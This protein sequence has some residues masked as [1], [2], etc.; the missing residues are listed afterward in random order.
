MDII[1]TAKVDFSVAEKRWVRLNSAGVKESSAQ[2]RVVS[3]EF[4]IEGDNQVPI[5]IVNEDD[6]RINRLSFIYADDLDGASKGILP[7]YKNKINVNMFFEKGYFDNKIDKL[8]YEIWDNESSKG[9]SGTLT[10]TGVDS[11]IFKDEQVELKIEFPFPVHGNLP[12][13]AMRDDID[14][15]AVLG[16][17]NI[18]GQDVTQDKIEMPFYHL[19]SDGFY[20]LSNL[21]LKKDEFPN[22]DIREYIPVQA[23]FRVLYVSEK[24]PGMDILQ[25]KLQIGESF[26][27]KFPLKKDKNKS[28]HVYMSDNMIII[29]SVNEKDLIYENGRKYMMINDKKY[30]VVLL[31]DFQGVFPYSFSVLVGS[32]TEVETVKKY[33]DKVAYTMY[34]LYNQIR[35]DENGDYYEVKDK[36]DDY[37]L[38][39]YEAI[40]KNIYKMG[41]QILPDDSPTFNKFSDKSSSKQEIGIFYYDGHGEVKS[42]DKEIPGYLQDKE[43]F[44]NGDRAVDLPEIFMFL[45]EENMSIQNMTAHNPAT[46]GKWQ[47][48]PIDLVYFNCCLVGMEMQWFKKYFNAKCAVGYKFEV[49]DK[50]INDI[51][52]Y[53]F[54]NFDK[55]DSEKEEYR[56]VYDVIKNKYD[57]VYGEIEYNPT[58]LS[59]DCPARII[60]PD[61]TFDEFFR[62]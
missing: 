28:G 26:S 37:E 46:L 9:Y 59:S 58:D 18:N 54:E 31:T 8:I 45:N 23:K 25:G 62:E 39:Q 32:I 47:A 22:N 52:N 44:L 13:I 5:M 49:F 10:E 41:F 20:H 27:Y 60:N 19:N 40:K 55:L 11:R 53:F 14:M 29:R 15:K 3:R 21:V 16:Y 7:L 33:N 6:R 38:K 56:R 42:Y 61:F 12:T 48:P 4:S 17:I 1:V 43:Q 34:S 57:D 50:D 30:E 35:K 2:T 24:D 51:A 36:K